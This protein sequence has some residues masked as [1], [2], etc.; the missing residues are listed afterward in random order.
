MTGFRWTDARV[1][2]ALGLPAEDGEAAL[3]YAGVSTDSRLIRPGELY[4]ALVG[5]RF[6]GH[7]FVAAALAAGARGVVVS[8]VRAEDVRRAVG[9][10]AMELY[11]VEDTLEA[12][13]RLAA[14]RRRALPAR[15]VGI[16][17]S[18]GKTGTKDLTAA[19]LG[20]ALRVHATRGNLNNQV[21]L[22][23]TLLAAPPDADVVVAEM[24]T[25]RPGEIAALTR[26]ARPEV[27]VVTTVGE[28]HLEGLGSVEGVLRE[29]LALLEGL[30]GERWGVV[31]DTP[32]ELPEAA[33]R[34]L[35]DVAVAGWT[36]RADP[37]LR[38]VEP[39]RDRCSAYGFSWRG[40]RVALAVPG[41]HAVTDALLALAVSERLGVD[42][43]VAARG[44]AS[45]RPGWMRGEVRRLGGLTLL[46]DC[47]NANPQSVRASMDLLVEWSAPRRV[48]VLGSML[49]LGEEGP[50]LHHRV[51]S[52][53][54][55]R[56]V[57]VVMATGAFAA[58]ARHVERSG[59][60][61]ELLAVD[62]PRA[63]Y[64][65]LRRR[66]RGD[67]AVLLKGSRGVALEALLP[68]F[69]ADFGGGDADARATVEGEEALPDSS[70]TEGE[71]EH[72]GGPGRE[73]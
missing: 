37:D 3:P 2:R 45:A 65:L 53:A 33:R 39:V 69:E 10:S 55:E 18:S 54:L 28:S 15:V 71:R 42:A 41:R 52:E 50:E 35:S 30:S 27:G 25:N 44:L 11:P 7:D 32:P 31:G 48:A 8:V 34:I 43:D 40:Q 49:E 63:G 47:Y 58:A 29:K 56:E 72:P 68:L 14:Y 20:G 64:A 36:E 70:R 73:G 60:G 61:P 67:E 5:E 21:G 26:I 1:R 13:G 9:S 22:P 59:S 16:T 4:V 19:A 57:D 51:L 23:L 46:L 38:P 62:D 6:D 66:L 12:L 24:G 17:G